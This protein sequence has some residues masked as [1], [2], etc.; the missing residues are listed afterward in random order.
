MDPPFCH[1]SLSFHQQGP[2]SFPQSNGGR[3][4]KRT[5]ENFDENSG[6]PTTLTFLPL[7]ALNPCQ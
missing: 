5:L 7:D 1:G 6:S 4:T 3:E 2:K